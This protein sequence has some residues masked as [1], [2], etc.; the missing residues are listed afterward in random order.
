[1]WNRIKKF[2]ESVCD[3]LGRCEHDWNNPYVGERSNEQI[4]TLPPYNEADIDFSV[5]A[6]RHP[7]LRRHDD[8]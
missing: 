4:D 5:E 6:L 8:E 2:M 3:A 1:M 7:D